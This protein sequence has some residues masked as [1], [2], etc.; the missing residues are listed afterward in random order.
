[1]PR[2]VIADD[3]YARITGSETERF[4]QGPYGM[5]PGRLRR[6]LRGMRSTDFRSCHSRAERHSIRRTVSNRYRDSRKFAGLPHSGSS[7]RIRIAARLSGELSRNAKKSMSRVARLSGISHTL[8]SRAPLS[9]NESLCAERLKRYSR[10]STAKYCKTSLKGLAVSL[11]TFSRR[12][13]TE[14]ATFLLAGFLTAALRDTDA[15]PFRPGT[16]SRIRSAF[17]VSASVGRDTGSAPLVR[18][19]CRSCCDT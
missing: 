14:A 16:L 13:C 7:G 1:M 11:A 4:D 9:T 17:S 15:S 8:N 12:W 6:I 2:P 18:Y 19:P 3:R 10:R 5:S